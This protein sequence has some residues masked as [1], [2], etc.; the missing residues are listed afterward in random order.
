MIQLAGEGSMREAKQRHPAGYVAVSTHS[1]SSNSLHARILAEPTALEAR[2]KSVL[3]E[4]PTRQLSAEDQAV[5]LKLK[6]GAS[7][8][9]T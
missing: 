5:E 9:I 1:G 6:L 4:H 8:E 7:S 3:W 2:V